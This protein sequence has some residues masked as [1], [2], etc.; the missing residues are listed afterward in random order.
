MGCA[1]S[2]RA[3]R[4]RAARNE[5]APARTEPTAHRIESVASPSRNRDLLSGAFLTPFLTLFSHFSRLTLFLAGGLT[6]P[7]SSAALSPSTSFF[8]VDRNA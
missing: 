5:S 2:L 6:L 3:L 8:F 1:D 4:P 7:G